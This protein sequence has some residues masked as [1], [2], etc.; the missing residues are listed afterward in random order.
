MLDAEIAETGVATPTEEEEFIP[1][2]VP[3]S[4]STNSGK[5][6]K[7]HGLS[8]AEISPPLPPTAGLGSDGGGFDDGGAIQNTI[9]GN[10]KDDEEEEVDSNVYE[11]VFPREKLANGVK[12]AKLLWGW[13]MTVAKES[14]VAVGNDPRVQAAKQRSSETFS[15]VASA[16]R[17]SVEALRESAMVS[18]SLDK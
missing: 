12:Q 13:G 18:A 3:L 8:D 1:L 5:E 2:P 17:N 16:T 15:S 9:D 6:P 10:D 4:S 7:D 14:A 11:K